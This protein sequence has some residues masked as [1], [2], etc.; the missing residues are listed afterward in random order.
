MDLKPDRKWPSRP[1]QLLYTGYIFSCVGDRLWT[2]AIVLLLEHLGGMR[3][4]SAN[5]LVDGVSAMLLSTFVGNWL[6]R[7]DRKVG[8]LTVLAVNNICKMAF[9]KDW[10]VVMA[11]REQSDSLSRRNA[12]MTTIDQLSSVIAPLITGYILLFGGYR[13]ACLVFVAWN[14]VSWAAERYLLSKVYSQVEELAVRERNVQDMSDPQF[15]EEI[16]ILLKKESSASKSSSA[17]MGVKFVRCWR[18]LERRTGKALSAYRRQQVFFAAIGLALLYM[19]V[20]GFDGLALS[21]GKSQYLPDNVLGAF[22]SVGS[23][24]GICGALSYTIFER[25]IGVRNTGFLGLSIQQGFLWLC[26]VSIW[27]PGSPFD[28]SG[29]ARSW[30][31]EGWIRSSAN[32]FSGSRI[33]DP[34]AGRTLSLLRNE[35]LSSTEILP[36]KIIS[37]T[38]SIN[39]SDWTIDGHPVV[40]VVVFFCGITF[41]RLGLWMADLSITQ[42]MQES[43]AEEERNTVF[44]AQNAF[45]QLFSVLKDI[46]VI[47]FPDPRTFGLLIAMSVGFVALG[48][49]SYCCYL[50]KIRRYGNNSKSSQID[51]SSQSKPD[52]MEQEEKAKLLP[53]S[54]SAPFLTPTPSVKSHNRIEITNELPP[55]SPS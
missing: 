15:K 28:P 33:E 4:V 3:L 39:W 48:F 52:D 45:C 11:N 17:N 24:L 8:A 34:A 18:R 46:V 54:P 50:I 51:L 29:Y 47:L 32:A 2:F 7:H 1:F 35:S 25:R 38:G 14:F 19:T 40:S 37:N 27:L 12:T 31:F 22:R 13:L 44:G 9:T 49:F 16:D 30:T 36:L 10:I 53:L 42:L 21:Y 55:S 26:L 43:I 41:A 6:D 23:V 5:Q 20:L